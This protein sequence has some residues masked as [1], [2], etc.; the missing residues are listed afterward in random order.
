MALAQ[1]SKS[2]DIRARL[3]HPVI[4][5]DGHTVE[6]EPL[7]LDYHTPIGGASVTERYLAWTQNAGLARW[8]RFPRSTFQC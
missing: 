3:D 4:D 5:A 2:A 7:F 8:A 1:T 6:Y